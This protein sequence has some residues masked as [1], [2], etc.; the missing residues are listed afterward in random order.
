M[1]RIL[2]LFF[3]L[4]I[5]FG[6]SAQNQWEE[7]TATADSLDLEKRFEAALPY[8]TKA[9][10]AT[11][12]KPY[13][14]QNKLLG[15]QMFTQAE[16]NLSRAKGTNPEDYTLMQNAVDLLQK[17]NAE[18]NR[19]SKVYFRLAEIAFDYMHK[20][21]DAEKYMEAAFDYYDKASEKDTLY[22]IDMMDFSGY[23]KIM[24]RNF[25]ESIATSKKAIELLD[26][27]NLNNH[28]GYARQA[29]IYYNLSLVYGVQF[30][31]IPLKEYQYTIESEKIFS[32]MDKPDMEPLILLYRRL[33]LF[34]RDYKNLEKAKGYMKKA[35][36]LYEKNKDEMRI[37]TG[38]K[39]ELSLYRANAVILMEADEEQQML[40]D[41]EKVEHI[42][43]NK[44][45]DEVEKGNY[46]GILNFI[47]LYYLDVKPDLKIAKKYNDKALAVQLDSKKAPYSLESFNQTAKNNKIAIYL[48]EK[49][50]Q[51][52]MTLISDTEKTPGYNTDKIT[53]KLKA[54]C[55]LGLGK[56][57]AAIDVIDELLVFINKDNKGFN[58][59]EDSIENFVSSYIISDAKLLAFLA[60][61][62]RDYYGKYTKEE[63]KLYWMAL[64]QMESNIDNTPLNKDLKKTFDKIT[65]G[66][67]NAALDRNFT[68]A[69]SNRLFTFMETLTSQDLVNN[70]LLK[71]EIAGNTELYKLVEEE[72]HIR[73]YITFLKK[74]HK[75]NKDENTKQQ[76][77]EKELELEEINRQLTSQYRQGN[78][79]IGPNIDVTA[80]RGKNIIKFNVAGNELFKTRLY[81]GKLT[82]H[83]IADYSKLKQDV[84][85]YLFLINNL[86]SSISTIKK[87]GEAL[88]KK[89]FN[90]EFDTN[91]PTV[92]IPDDIFHYLPFEL[93]VKGNSYLI[94]NHTISYASSFYFLNTKTIA[95]KDSQK[96]KMVLFAPEYVGTPQESLLAVRGAPYSLAGAAEEV[97]EIAKY[98]SAKVYVGD[99]ASK[100]KFKSLG[101]DISVLHLAMHSNLNDEDPEL[102][103]LVFSNSEQDYEMYISELYGLNFNAHLAV[104][105]ACN[106][107][108][109]GF[110]D[111]GNLISMHHA[112]ITAGIPATIAS[113][114]NAPDKSTKE[115]MIA[116]YK[117]LQQGHDK[118]IALRKAKLSYL[119]NTNDENL[120]HPFY[121]AG[122]VLSGDESPIQLE[123]NLS[124]ESSS[125]IIFILVAV[126]ILAAVAFFLLRRRKQITS[127]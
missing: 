47:T 58:F 49:D 61:S 22:L 91:V 65:S 114:W 26:Q 76:L 96:K 1:N 64:A 80:T 6:L 73:S 94:E 109:G 79:F 100:T 122:F 69:E 56:T 29:K 98:I 28:E 66:L 48:L 89:I 50:Y 42:V 38:Y 118:A 20:G 40:N 53:L 103:N 87:Q 92:I 126:T 112:F 111:G 113:L 115:I 45:L 63:E 59:S 4:F 54:E 16:Y 52:A 120:Q 9:L 41:L 34:E 62:F 44:T 125:T 104:L 68:T 43:K 15:L 60:K 121:W 101:S 46:K 19:I 10:E 81:N 23:I 107:G 2:L 55:L 95:K 39:L 93:L 7:L 33:A 37:L 57:E 24:S 32:K 8:R 12:S 86:E 30:L 3:S 82:Y 83:K 117:N 75:K 78:L 85:N 72:Q 70:F 119:N 97:N 27:L 123:A 84:K 35:M 14:I 71:R 110:Q 90:D 124:W 106:T 17:T 18:P 74:Q 31:N 21:Q 127:A 105:S 102:S 51:K 108:V 99:L 67:L 25:E 13:S 116:F 11:K 5:S 77:F 36:G 88:Y